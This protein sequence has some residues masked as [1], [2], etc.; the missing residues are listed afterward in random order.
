MGL[1]K[2]AAFQRQQKKKHNRK[3]NE[4]FCTEGKSEK[5]KKRI[6]YKKPTHNCSKRDKRNMKTQQ[7]RNKKEQEQRHTNI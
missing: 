3:L 4:N 5:N 7:K 2:K 6:P 1:I